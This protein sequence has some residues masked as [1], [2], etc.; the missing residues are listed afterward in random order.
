MTYTKSPGL[1]SRWPFR[2]ALTCALISVAGW[3]LLSDNSLLTRRAQAAGFVVTNTNDSGAGSLRQAISDA[4]ANGGGVIDT[5]T[6]NIPGAGV[7]SIKPASPLPPI[8]TPTT[9]DGFSQP[10]AFEGISTTNINSI[11][12]IELDGSNAGSTAIGLLIQGANTTIKGLVINRFA[13]SGIIID[14]ANA[15]IQGNYIGT[16]AAGTAALGNGAGVSFR[17]N[18]K[19]SIV[20]GLSAWMRNLISGNKGDG[21][22]IGVETNTNIAVQGNLI[23][24]DRVGTKDVGNEGYGV[25]TLNSFKVSIGGTAF[26][27]RNVISGNEQHG[28]GLGPGGGEHVVKGNFIGLQVD[29]ASPLG[30]SRAGI[31]IV[32]PD[33][34]IG[35]PADGNL[36]AFNGNSGVRVLVGSGNTISANSIF[37]NKF[38]GID[39]GPGFPI[40]NDAG[41]IDTGENNRQNFPVV[42]SAVN[43]AALVNTA[44]TL[45]SVGGTP[46]RIEFFVSPQCDDSGYGEGKQY[47]D[48]TTVTTNVNGDASFSLTLGVG[49]L[50]PQFITATATDLFGNTSGFSPCTL[51]GTVPVPTISIADVSQAEGNNGSKAFDFTVTLSAASKQTV[52]VNYAQLPGT[53]TQA[54]DYQVQAATLVFSPGETSKTATVFVNSDKQDEPDETFFVQLSNPKNASLARPQA[55]GTIINDD[56]PGSLSLQFSASNYSVQEDMGAVTL[57]VIRFG[58]A[59]DPASVDYATVDNTAKQ[60]HDYG[61][62]LGTLSFAPGETSKTLTVLINEDAHI[63]GNETLQV[64]LSNPVGASLG[65]ISSSSV[66]IVDDMPESAT[67]PIDD[68]EAF[69]YS[70]YHD[71]LNREPDAAGFQF[72]T[73]EITSCGND[74][75]CIEVKRVNISAAFFLSIEFQQTGYIR[76]LMEKESFGSTP[77][78]VEFMRDVQQLGRG[79]TVGAPGWQQ[80]VVDNQLQFADQWVSRP[81]FKSMYDGLSN[82]AFVNQ[83]YANTGFVPSAD[84]KQFLIAA[85]DDATY[86]RAKV[87]LIITLSPALRSHE[88]NA[89]FVLMQYFGYLRRDPQTAPDSDLTGY[90]F[91]LFKL[92]SFNGNYVDAEM[93][94]AFITSFEYRQRFAQ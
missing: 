8:V 86:S 70:H 38:L 44:G 13:S 17:S 1:L 76:Y 53:A 94:K 19:D 21:V 90:N 74:V 2:L 61:I 34:T 54:L 15:R 40:P 92:N 30:N 56:A 60:K 73:K 12:I 50:P 65:Q 41:D 78:Y 35:G 36:I 66:T 10:G 4:N 55:L 89:A 7:K 93:V 83:L 23:G 91:W 49:G 57:T 9:I 42:T 77:K 51:I 72:W 11:L 25:R 22:D 67:N 84:D 24:T 81:E 46:Y 48:S 3:T 87:V 6:F 45:H 62:A 79:V 75:Q 33:N 64:V 43:M 37:S 80:K 63:E 20:G 85:L 88:Q 59:S 31:E 69:V 52:S 82:A 32:S 26:E 27:A 47:L 16:D 39:L 28:I 29:A 5:I 68:A 58:D 14:A 18:G 71:F